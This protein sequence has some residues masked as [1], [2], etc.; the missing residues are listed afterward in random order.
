MNSVSHHILFTVRNMYNPSIVIKYNLN[1]I[2]YDNMLLNKYI[3]TFNS[4][5]TIRSYDKVVYLDCSL[6]V[7]KLNFRKSNFIKWKSKI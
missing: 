3:M 1:D 6:T 2:H 4:F 7:V 5:D